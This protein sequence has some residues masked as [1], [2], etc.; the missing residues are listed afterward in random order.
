MFTKE[1]LNQIRSKGIDIKNINN[2]IKNF[3]IGFPDI[4]LT[5]AA[6]LEK[7]IKPIDDT[8]AEK[9]SKFFDDHASEKNIIKFV[10]ASGAASRM[11]KHL[12][13]FI[14][15]GDYYE[16]FL[17]ETGFNTVS[18]FIDNL[19]DFAFFYDLKLILQ[20]NGFD[21]DELLK[22]KDYK[23]VIEFL[24]L[25]KGLNYSSLPK[26]LLKFHQYKE[27]SR[28]PVE[29]HL[30]EGANLCR[31][32]NN[33]VRIHLTVSTEHKDGFDKLI[34]S[35]RKYYEE[36][37]DVKYN[38]EF[39]FQKPSTDTIAVDLNIEPFRD[40]EGKLVFRPG[41]HGALIENLNDTRAEMVFIKNIDNVVPDKLKPTSSLYKKVIGGYLIQLQNRIND[42]L[43]LMEAEDID[44]SM[45]EEIEDFAK[46]ELFIGFHDDY[47][48]FNSEEKVHFLFSQL[49]RPLRVCGM[50]KNE[51]E[52]GGGP[53]F[54]RNPEGEESLQI[55][56]GAQINSSDQEQKE[57]AAKATHFNP[58]DLVCN[59]RNYKG[60]QYNLHEYIDH[61]TGMISQKSKD[62]KDLKA[63]ELP[64]LWNGAMADWI[65]V[66]VE[67]PLITFNPVKTV[68]DLLRE[69]HR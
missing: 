20:D 10:P 44:S 34:E 14:D 56:E 13:E 23:T 48:G 55:I 18:N 58:V 40:E 68:N 50:V 38:I 8:E 12:H 57:I 32:E 47:F 37:Y 27:Y 22:N 19:E 39:S 4:V 26:G 64:G 66:F 33:S 60:E 21:I 11:F 65:T 69:Q 28:T 1:D 24:L 6:T 49:N 2:Q 17:K 63:Q 46:N 62:G 9:L 52:P 15:A 51:G 31:D 16:E 36:K 45:I 54:V 3:K 7:G 53:F 35:V 43:K 29:E 67:V 59:L 5:N 30:V 42:Y 61:K 41:G 25:Q